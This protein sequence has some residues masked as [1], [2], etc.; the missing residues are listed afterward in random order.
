MSAQEVWPE[1]GPHT[2]HL[3]LIDRLVEPHPDEAYLRDDQRAALE[4]LSYEESHPRTP[5]LVVVT[6]DQGEE[7]HTVA[8]MLMCAHTR[9]GKF[10]VA[11]ALFN[12]YKQKNPD[13]R[14]LYLANTRGLVKNSRDKFDR[15]WGDKFTTG[16]LHGGKKEF[17][18]FDM[19]FST[20]QSMADSSGFRFP[21]RHFGFKIVDENHHSEAP[22]FKKVIQY[23]I[24]DVRLGTT[25]T[26]NRLDKLDTRKTFGQ[27]VVDVPLAEGIVRGTLRT[28]NYKVMLENNIRDKLEAGTIDTAT[29]NR[30]TQRIDPNLKEMIKRGQE[31]INKAGIK[32]PMVLHFA[33]SIQQAEDIASY[34]PNSSILHSGQTDEQND[35]AIRRFKEGEVDHV[36]SIN[37]LNEG[38]DVPTANVIAF[39]R[40][41]ESENIFIQQL[42]R[43]LEPAEDGSPLLV[44]D[45]VAN[46]RRLEFVY[47]LMHGITNYV[48]DLEEYKQKSQSE[49]TDK[50]FNEP[51][52]VNVPRSLGVNFELDEE[53][54]KVVETIV[55][56]REY[57][58]K[59]K[60]FENLTEFEA[61]AY[62]QMLGR[63][64]VAKQHTGLSLGLSN[65]KVT[66]LAKRGEG[67]TSQGLTTATRMRA[68]D[69]MNSVDYG[70]KSKEEMI[71]SI[72]EAELP[73][74]IILLAQDIISRHP[75]AL[76]H[77][78]WS[79]RSSDDKLLAFLD[80]EVN[81]P[82]FGDIWLGMNQMND[83]VIVRLGDYNFRFSPTDSVYSG[84]DPAYDMKPRCSGWDIS[85]TTQDD[86]LTVGKRFFASDK[87]NK[88]QDQ[89][90]AFAQPFY[91]NAQA[92]DAEPL[93]I[94]HN[95]Q[96]MLTE[97]FTELVRIR[98]DLS[99][100][101]TLNSN[102]PFYAYRSL[103]EV[104]AFL[105]N[106]KGYNEDE[107]DK[108]AD[109]RRNIV[110]TNTYVEKLKKVIKIG[111]Q[112][113]FDWLDQSKDQPFIPL[114][115]QEVSY[116]P[117]SNKVT[118]SSRTN[119]NVALKFSLDDNR[120]RKVGSD[121]RTL[122]M[123][124]IL[125]NGTTAEFI[126]GF[127]DRVVELKISKFKQQTSSIQGSEE[128]GHEG[129][130]AYTQG[131]LERFSAKVNAAQGYIPTTKLGDFTPYNDEI[132]GMSVD[133]EHPTD[134]SAKKDFYG[135]VKKVDYKSGVIEVYNRLIHRSGQEKEG[136]YTRRIKLV[137]KSKQGS[138]ETKPVFKDHLGIHSVD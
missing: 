129:T 46:A 50:G 99:N 58:E 42:G 52:W 7:Q 19:L 128:G 89:T 20:F 8:N 103:E 5:E 39:Y 68:V 123:G 77:V 34:L 57:M 126:D 86:L 100:D 130:L 26:P 47:N 115:D 113:N 9:W 98:T 36:I 54:L 40:S 45:Y 41:T 14:G 72:S 120:M 109:D 121:V 116:D 127:Y 93:S 10:E 16:E 35:E 107:W 21:R 132:I 3:H 124:I 22:S 131:W 117:E 65:S 67:P 138:F 69:I 136:P 84:H 97:L 133:F 119:P 59:K 55:E 38:I 96:G 95:V 78:D 90:L 122:D 43:G 108:Y 53:L 61:L 30:E 94:G 134:Q 6:T 44:L 70:M 60:Q 81:L 137:R 12:R 51:D 66:E 18:E 31:E 75:E 87:Y 29:L 111:S 56:Q 33:Q 32:D 85:I 24:P 76:A 112:V 2:T 106:F 79:T 110:K 63:R 73:D 4:I 74:A 114:S 80:K 49:P 104:G 92:D 11:T 91:H 62:V 27:E 48:L 17:D 82:E 25:A 125:P 28:M 71:N 102:Y 101:G 105:D 23:F 37:M 13:A 83:Y 118:V 64:Q 88:Y 135:I 15:R 1:I